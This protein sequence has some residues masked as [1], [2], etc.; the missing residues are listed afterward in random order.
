MPKISFSSLAPKV[1]RYFKS[2]FEQSNNF[3]SF[4]IS[5]KN[6]SRMKL[7]TAEGRKRRVQESFD[8]CWKFLK[9]TILKKKTIPVDSQNEHELSSNVQTWKNL[10]PPSCLETKRRRA[11]LLDYYPALWEEHEGSA[12]SRNSRW[13]SRGQLRRNVTAQYY[14]TKLARCIRTMGPNYVR[15]RL[16]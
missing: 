14:S 4:F 10:E 16:H 12:I 3:V 11:R 1:D 9:P 13:C 2:L 7:S 6:I 8:Y 5:S 15:Y